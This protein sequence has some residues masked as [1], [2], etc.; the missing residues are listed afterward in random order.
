MALLTSLPELL[1]RQA[2]QRPDAVAFIEDGREISF[3]QF[4]AMCRRTAVWLAQ[5]GIGRDDRVAVWMV[6]RVEWLALYFALSHLGAVLVTVNTRYRAHELAFILQCSRAR[7]L[8]LEPG[9]R[10]IDFPTVLSGVDPSAARLLECIAVVRAQGDA[11]LAQAAAV[12]GRPVVGFDLDSLPDGEPPCAGHSQAFNILFT[13]SGTTSGPKL[14]VHRQYSIAVHSQHVAHAFGLGQPGSVLLSTLPLCGVFGFNGV[15]GAFAGGRPTVIASTF[16]ANE[17]A[18]LVVQHQVTHLFGSDEMFHRLMEAAPGV[19]P[20]PSLRVCAFASFHPGAQALGNEAW[21][22]GIPLTGLYGSSEVQALF[23]YNRQDLP[24]EE[25]LK[26]G[27]TPSN[28]GARLRIRDADTGALLAPGKSGLIEIKAD[29]NFAEYLDNPQA[30]RAA[31]DDDGYFHTGDIGYLRDDG[32]FVYQTRH[33]DAIRLAG[34][35]VD[36][37][38]IEEVIKH[39]AGVADA[40]VVAVETPGGQ[41]RCAAFVIAKAGIALDTAALQA[42]LAGLLAAF[43]VPAYIWQVQEFPSTQSSNG[44]KI[45]RAKLR[46]MAQARIEDM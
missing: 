16:D 13:T 7:M 15:L 38:E 1:A 42:A 33:G 32:S 9:F 12:L 40:Q 29:T 37:T 43:K 17:A 22:R 20:F 10:K 23:S 41:R 28:P 4:A 5:H 19:R 3:G 21:A 30:T 2:A 39:Q 24:M 26:G 14:V 46:D 36:P 27:G 25:R 18:R 31:I 44:V 45:Q 35:L 6:N 8:V 34:F 11:G